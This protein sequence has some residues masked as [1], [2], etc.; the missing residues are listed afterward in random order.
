MHL[1]QSFAMSCECGQRLQVPSSATGRVGLCPA[2]GRRMRIAA[3]NGHEGDASGE[4]DAPTLKDFR[5][6]SRPA[7]GEDVK[8]LFGKAVDLFRAG[9][10]A[11]A[12]AIFDTFARQFPDNAEIAEARNYC[13][14]ALDRSSAAVSHDRPPALPDGAQL[15]AETVKRIVLE[16][17]L[18]GPTAAVQLE[19]AKLAC[20]M[21]G[22]FQE[23]S[24]KAEKTS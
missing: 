16:K 2:C 23:P 6:W 10:Y 12:L 21:L 20:Q 1:M 5:S 15:D 3:N 9:R 17:L 19:A 7:L 24:T 8:H 13:L 18:H 4:P 11:E 22:L 14:S